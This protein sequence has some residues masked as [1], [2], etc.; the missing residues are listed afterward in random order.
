MM[1]SQELLMSNIKRQ[2]ELMR[3]DAEQRRLEL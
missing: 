2:E 1:A 3:Q